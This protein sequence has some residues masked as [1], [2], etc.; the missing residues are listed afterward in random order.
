MKSKGYIACPNNSHEWREISKKFEELW[1]FPNC[2]GAIDG[3][4]I[5]M[6][7]PANSGS[8]FFNYKKTNSIVLL[9]TCDALYRFTMVDIGDTGRNSDSGV[10]ANSLMGMAINQKKLNLPKDRFLPGSKD[11]FPYVF[12]C[13]EV[14]ALKTCMLKPYAR[15]NLDVQRRIFNYRLSRARRVI[16]N[17]FGICAS[18]FRILRR[19]IIRKPETVALITKAIVVLHNYLMVHESS[20]Y[21]PPGHADMDTANGVRLGDWRG[22]TEGFTGLTSIGVQGSNNYTKTASE[23]RDQFCSYFNSNAGSV[24][25]QWDHATSTVD[26]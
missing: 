2:A 24:P 14:F 9:A 23:V 21:C 6:Q 11:K 17:C 7:Q 1:N 19:P 13:D 3:K 8:T 26:E 20:T 22:E 15:Q 25:W 12:V 4:H 5:V 18:R 10:F 16:E